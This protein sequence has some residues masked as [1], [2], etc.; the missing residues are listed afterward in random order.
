[1]GEL[2]GRLNDLTAR[3]NAVAGRMI[4]LLEAAAF[5]DEPI[6]RD[7]AQMLI[8]EAQGLLASVR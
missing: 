3:R 8:D 7:E 1:M 6:D 4:A 5:G 2:D